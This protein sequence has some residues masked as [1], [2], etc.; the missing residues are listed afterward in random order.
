[1]G[2]DRL[3]RR[4][5]IHLPGPQVEPGGVQRTLDLGALEPPVGQRGVLMRAGVVD[6]EDLAVLGVED[7]HRWIDGP[8]VRFATRDGAEWAY[9]SQHRSSM[10]GGSGCGGGYRGA[11]LAPPPGEE[12]GLVHAEHGDRLPVALVE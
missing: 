12:F 2:T 1:M 8:P 9:G 3:L 6:G 7:G 4:G 11:Q 5:R 10:A